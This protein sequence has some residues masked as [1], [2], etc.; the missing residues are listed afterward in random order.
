MSKRGAASYAEL[1]SRSPLS[2]KQE[3]R[4]HGSL[5][6][7][8]SSK[9]TNYKPPRASSS[10]L[11]PHDHQLSSTDKQH[12]DFM[13]PRSSY[14]APTPAQSQGFATSL[15]HDQPLTTNTA[16]APESHI[17]HIPPSRYKESS[18][19]ISG[20]ASMSSTFTPYQTHR[21]PP[22]KNDDVLRHGG[23]TPLP[24]IDV[25]AG[26]RILSPRLRRPESFS[27]P[28]PSTSRPTFSLVP[29]APPLKRT[30]SKDHHT[31]VQLHPF[32]RMSRHPSRNSL[33][34]PPMGENT[35]SRYSRSSSGSRKA[36]GL[37][38][39]GPSYEPSYNSV[40]SSHLPQ[41]VSTQ[42]IDTIYTHGSWSRKNSPSSNTS[43]AHVSES[44][45]WRNPSV[46]ERGPTTS[47]PL[48]DHQIQRPP[49]LYLELN[50]GAQ[51]G[52][53][54]VS[55]NTNIASKQ[56]NEKRKRNASASAKFR[57]RKKAEH[58]QNKERIEQLEDRLTIMNA[59]ITKFYTSMNYYKDE[60]Y[61]LR[62]LVESVPEIA[63]RTHEGCRS[64]V[65]D[66]PQDFLEW[67]HTL[68]NARSD[69][70]QRQGDSADVASS[71]TSE[72][73]LSISRAVSTQSTPNTAIAVH[74]DQNVP[75]ALASSSSHSVAEGSRRI[76]LPS[77]AS[78]AGPST[79]FQTSTSSDVNPEITNRS[80]VVYSGEVGQQSKQSPPSASS[81]VERLPPISSLGPYSTRYNSPTDSQR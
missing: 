80:Q 27:G 50:Q 69:Q 51:R 65:L 73:R 32:E 5:K 45:M 11:S 8:T 9:A 20:H 12:P 52:L 37:L 54:P 77:S 35:E 19:P 2:P 30:L 18:R 4:P 58:V 46:N 21:A 44:R 49:P 16:T 66:V 23:P 14:G 57:Q 47:H 55:I 74:Q 71:S 63:H 3:P 56:A 43:P 28:S 61:R 15:Y 17:P 38:R 76:H 79:Y 10:H 62:S 60:V 70:A 42:H 78:G 36:D 81:N 31:D 67:L 33:G 75:G 1:A 22:I 64:P 25:S 53:I 68:Q 39:H 34:Y 40:P 48:V 41:A 13:D 72:K 29:S 59:Q 6:V 24:P 7:E 26:R